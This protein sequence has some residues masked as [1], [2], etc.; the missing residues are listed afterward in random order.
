MTRRVWLVDEGSPGHRVQS[1][2]VLAAL[3]ARGIAFETTR[4]AV[5]PRLRGAL[6]PV[7]RAVFSRLDGRAALAFARV[8][9]AFDP[10]SG[11]APAFV[12]GSAGGSAF[13][14]RGLARAAGAPS[15]FVGNPKPIPAGWFDAVLSPIPL[16]NAPD[17]ILTGVVPSPMRPETCAA[18]AA[19]HWGGPPPP[20]LWAMLVGGESRNHHFAPEDFA[21]LGRAVTALARAHGV[22]W[23]IATSR[24]TGSEGEAALAAA[25]DPGVVE[26]LALWGAAPR[27]VVAPF[28]GAA[29]LV[30]VTQDSLTMLSEALAAGKRTI[31]AAPAAVTLAPDNFM[32]RLLAAFEALPQFSRSSIAA[33]GAVDPGP[34]VGRVFPETVAMADAAAAALARQFALQEGAPRC[35]GPSS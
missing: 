24:R 4:V 30:V 31:A 9:A 1:E 20:G 16:A 25:L 13:A 19:T 21:G 15:V 35:G 32:A 3:A 23:L 34:G 18:A 28:L 33:L 2:G 29:G 26:D 8:V 17:A 27:K 14:L 22:R 11:P 6:R 10:P 5:R 7:A 12:V